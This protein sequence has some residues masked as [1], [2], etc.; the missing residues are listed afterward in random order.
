[1]TESYS[2]SAEHERPLP[3]FPYGRFFAKFSVWEYVPM[4]QGGKLVLLNLIG[5]EDDA[6][7]ANA[8]MRPDFM[9]NWED[10][11]YLE[12][13]EI[14]KSVWLNR[15]YFLASF[16]NIH[17]KTSEKWALDWI[18]DFL[19]EWIR[20]NPP[21][22]GR[23]EGASKYTWFDMQV[24]WR[25]YILAVVIQLCGDSLPE[26]ERA[27]LYELL[28]THAKRLGDFFA[29]Q[30][31]G[32]GNHQSHGAFA[33]LLAGTLFPGL[34][35]AGTLRARGLE[36]LN[37]H[38]ENAFFGDGNSVELSPG[39]YPFI[40]SIFRD[41]FL[42]C[43]ENG[44]ALDGIWERRLRQFHRFLKLTA[45]PDMTTPPVNDST[46]MPVG[47]SVAVLED[48]LGI[49]PESVPV[50]TCAFA[51]SNQAVMRAGRGG[52]DYI[53]LDAGGRRLWHWHCGKLGFQFWWR[54]EPLLVD[55]G[56]SNYDDP[57]REIWYATA[58]AHNTILVDGNGDAMRSQINFARMSDG[59][60]K[61]IC[62]EDSEAFSR[63]AMSS[64]IAAGNDT[65]NWVRNII[66]VKGRFVIVTDSVSG[67]MPHDV[68][69]LFHGAAGSVA[70]RFDDCAALVKTAGTDLLI[71]AFPSAG[72]P[73]LDSTY[74]PGLV[75][76]GGSNLRGALARFRARG[77]G[78]FGA[79][80]LYPALSGDGGGGLSLEIETV[81]G[82]IEL[83]VEHAGCLYTVAVTDGA[84]A[85]GEC[86]VDCRAAGALQ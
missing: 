46:E 7:I 73:R 58:A 83:A 41:A 5:S 86:G 59:P 56:V 18:I 64:R 30:P 29:P 37:H 77:T 40:V 11:A 16:A 17:A 49:A 15:W 69:W 1:M 80:L 78:V 66:M 52:G 34:A 61:L 2:P 42:L 60:S 8:L 48:I 39:Y 81:P 65:V 33:M 70:S 27:F 55:S 50:E 79:F 84:I 71:K 57:L 35:N 36:I 3:R 68:Q 85:G 67:D 4:D 75:N 14:E 72:G 51:E 76:R 62:L 54:S 38:M 21:G 26:A 12:E 19:H 31:F 44:I 24:A 53:F 20:K 43:R 6:G 10:Q 32:V 47:V 22:G 28:E 45:Q 74:P 25:T 63:G 82:G 9:K 13:T 23:A